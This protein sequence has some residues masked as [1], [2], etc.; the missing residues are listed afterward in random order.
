MSYID[1]TCDRC[2]LLWCECQTKATIRLVA[3]SLCSLCLEG[4][5]GE[6]HVPGCALFINRAPDLPVDA[7]LYN[8]ISEWPA[9]DGL[10]M[11][12]GSESEAGA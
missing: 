1:D 3:I 12:N 9:F 8:V 7:R 5:G 6:C 2:G 11:T 10:E 4:K